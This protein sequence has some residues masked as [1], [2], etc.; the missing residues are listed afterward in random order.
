MTWQDPL[1]TDSPSNQARL[2][3]Y[4]TMALQSFNASLAA[5]S[6]VLPVPSIDTFLY[7]YGMFP[8]ALPTLASALQSHLSLTNPFRISAQDD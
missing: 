3:S 2:F 8:T 7:A 1:W 6:R 5:S 4:D